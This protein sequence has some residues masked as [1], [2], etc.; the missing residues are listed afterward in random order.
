MARSS[1]ASAPTLL[2]SALNMYVHRRRIVAEDVI[3]LDLRASDGAS[4]PKWEAGA[5]LNVTL[6]ND[7]VR[8]YSLCG[9]PEDRTTYRIAVLRVVD[10]RGGSQFIHESLHE[11]VHLQVSVPRN[12][13]RFEN[14][15]RYLFIAGGIGIT[16]LIPMVRAAEKS[17][18]EW[19]ILYG[20]RTAVSMAYADLITDLGGNRR[21]DV[22]QQDV[23]GLPNIDHALSSI[24]DD[25]LVYSCGPEPL[26]RAIEDRCEAYELMPNLRLERFSVPEVTDAI[27]STSFEVEVSST[28]DVFTVPH[29]KSIVEV[30]L[31]NGLDIEV[32]CR[33]GTCGT[34]ETG[35]IEGAVDHRDVVLSQAEKD[36]GNLMMVCV[37]RAKCPRLVLDL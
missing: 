27:V 29:D 17:G 20:G 35:V 23:H 37:S 16:P 36:Q 9:D 31:S 26:L 22:V 24:R 19:R 18:A 28:G 13:F 21:V 30:L 3:E 11:Q 5:H 34:C 15:P 12:N 14:A 6:P 25:T 4:L 8:Q 32:S 33:E 7:V 10:G 1:A 2:R